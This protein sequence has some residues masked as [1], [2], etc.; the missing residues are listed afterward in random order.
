MGVFLRLAVREVRLSQYC[1]VKTLA[2]PCR[3][4]II[5]ETKAWKQVQNGYNKPPKQQY[6]RVSGSPP[7]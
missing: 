5:T 3:P 4:L 2:K 7:A 1:D 6:A